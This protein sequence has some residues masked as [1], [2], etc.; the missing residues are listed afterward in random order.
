[1]LKDMLRLKISL[2][3]YSTENFKLYLLKKCEMQLLFKE[4]KVFNKFHLF[5][6]VFNVIYQENL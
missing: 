1:M 5:E 4:A 2:M 3:G 6:C